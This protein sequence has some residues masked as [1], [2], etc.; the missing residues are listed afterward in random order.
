MVELSD[1]RPFPMDGMLLQSSLV[2]TDA[3]WSLR[4]SALSPASG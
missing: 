1:F 3:N 2:K 4:I